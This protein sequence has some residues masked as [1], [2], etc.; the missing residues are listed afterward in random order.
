[1]AR[2]TLSWVFGSVWQTAIGGAPF[3]LFA[4]ELRASAM[5]IGI[6]AALP[7]LA[8]LVSMPASLLTERTGARKKIF[9]ISLYTQRLL[10]IPIAIV[11]LWM[12]SH[13]HSHASAVLIFMAMILLMHGAGAVGGPG[14]LS[15]MA[16][17]VPDRLRGKYFSR[18][19]QWGIVSAI[20]AA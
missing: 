6:L 17:I 11:P 4:R 8:S 18:R 2:V 19:R 7:F 10:W 9:L 14:W 20:P 16:D 12:L 15:W 1:M 13:G 5:Q 3:S